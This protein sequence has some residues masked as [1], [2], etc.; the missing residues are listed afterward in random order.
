MRSLINIPKHN[1]IFTNSPALE[2]TWVAMHRGR[3]D[4]RPEEAEWEPAIEHRV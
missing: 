2:G 1:M 4:V 3:T